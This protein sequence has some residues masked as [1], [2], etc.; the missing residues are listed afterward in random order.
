[1]H[2]AIAEI[3]V[4]IAELRELA[5][6]LHPSALSSDGLAGALDDLAA[7]S[8]IPI[9]LAATEE[10]F[11]AEVETTAWFIACEAVTNAVKHANPSAIEVTVESR[12]G[13]LHICIS[14]DGRGGADP[15]GTGLRG[16]ADR[17]EAL[18]G[19]LLIESGHTGG[20]RIHAEL[21]CA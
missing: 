7:R 2:H 19:R 3:Q 8:P 20:T 21:P 16:I 5:N 17:A 18:G 9:T 15:A 14:D 12:A 10:R 13:R 11:G 4:A 6:G 1:M